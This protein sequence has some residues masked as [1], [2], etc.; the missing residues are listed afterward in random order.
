MIMKKINPKCLISGMRLPDVYFIDGEFPKII[1]R[2]EDIYSVDTT[3]YPNTGDMD[4]IFEGIVYYDI[5]YEAFTTT[6]H[7]HRSQRSMEMLFPNYPVP[8]ESFL[9]GRV[10]DVGTGTGN[11]VTELS[12]NGFAAYGIDIFLTLDQF[13][14]PYFAPGMMQRTGFPDMFFTTIIANNSTYLLTGKT[15]LDAIKEFHRLLID[16]GNVIIY[17]DGAVDNIGAPQN[18]LKAV[19]ELEGEFKIDASHISTH[20]YLQLIKI[21]S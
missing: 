4:Q 11:L 10:L 15:A 6:G 9:S 1:L 21:A 3:F 14:T 20:N 17:N 16:G 12:R 13:M 8:A 18:M 19:N 5:T 2:L 7:I